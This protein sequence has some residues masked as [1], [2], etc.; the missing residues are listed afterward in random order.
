LFLGNVYYDQ[1]SYDFNLVKW[2]DFPLSR[3]TKLNM[4]KNEDSEFSYTRW[5]RINKNF[6]ELYIEI[7]M[8]EMHTHHSSS[9]SIKGLKIK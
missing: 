8:M 5:I 3:I 1:L 6:E 2:S 4:S 9:K 7:S